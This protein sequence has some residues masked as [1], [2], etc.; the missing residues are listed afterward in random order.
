MRI[1]VVHTTL[2][3]YSSPVYLEPHTIRL[4]P[5]EDTTQRL[6]SWTLDL[7]RPMNCTSTHDL[8]Y[9]LGGTSVTAANVQLLCRRHNLSKGAKIL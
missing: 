5:R 9:S 3:R 1:A 6:A 7:E 4:R 8:P 2:Y